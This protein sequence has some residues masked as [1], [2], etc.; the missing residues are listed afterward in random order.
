MVGRG[1]CRPKFTIVTSASGRRG[2]Q[3]TR[4]LQKENI[5]LLNNS[6]RLGSAIGTA[7]FFPAVSFVQAKERSQ[8]EFCDANPAFYFFASARAF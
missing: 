5:E 4:G 7:A 1:L 3:Q 6:C 2:Y 8:I